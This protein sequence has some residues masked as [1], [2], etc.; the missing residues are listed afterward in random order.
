M[1]RGQW[2][3][4]MMRCHGDKRGA[5]DSEAI[6]LPPGDVANSDWP[7]EHRA[8]YKVAYDVRGGNVDLLD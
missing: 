2:Q 6:L 7:P 5:S 4:D 8:F 1:F 3:A